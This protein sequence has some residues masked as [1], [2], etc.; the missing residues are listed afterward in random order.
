MID[1]L[2]LT[3]SLV[4]FDLETTGVN[5]KE[6]RIVEIAALIIYPDGT[7]DAYQTLVNPEIP[8]PRAASNVHNI[9]DDDVK[10]A[11]TFA[12]LSEEL[13]NLFYNVDL[14]GYNC[15][16]FDIP[17]LQNEFT[18][19]N[20]PVE[21]EAAFVIDAM[22]IFRHYQKYTLAG[23]VEFYC[24][25]AIKDAHEDMA[26]VDATVEVIKSQL[27]R[28]KLPSV[29]SQIPEA[30]RPPGSIDPDG[31]LRMI[32]DEPT[33]TFGKHAGTPLRELETGYIHWLIRQKVIPGQIDLLKANLKR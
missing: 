23:A 10:E 25:H 4:V 16:K 11:P 27:I 15:I 28:Y 19:A 13:F 3:R 29:V 17:L 12:E 14:G 7:T 2:K 31:K 32:N 33:I 18:R 24:G 21:L 30:L 9:F 26:D 8:I 1:L 22:Q 20:V 5:V 6:D